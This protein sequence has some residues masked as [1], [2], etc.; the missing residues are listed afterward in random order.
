MRFPLE[1]NISFNSYP[2]RV[3]RAICNHNGYDYCYCYYHFYCP[4][5][6]CDYYCE[7]ECVKCIQD[8]WQFSDQMSYRE[9]LFYFSVC[10]VQS[11]SKI[12][13][14]IVPFRVAPFSIFQV[15]TYVVNICESHGNILVLNVYTFGVNDK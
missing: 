14:H 7:G 9:D 4:P 11:S 13:K 2:R 12:H 5:Y 10:G 15:C 8:F 3:C 6:A 1:A